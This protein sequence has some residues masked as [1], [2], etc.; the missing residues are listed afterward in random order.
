[1]EIT[2]VQIVAL[3]A[4]VLALSFGAIAYKTNFC[5]MGAVSDWVNMSDKRRLRAWFLAIGV[6]ILGT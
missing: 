5:T 6:A 2:T 4:F 3:W 1:M